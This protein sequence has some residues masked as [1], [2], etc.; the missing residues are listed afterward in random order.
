MFVGLHALFA[1]NTNTPELALTNEEGEAFMKACQNVMRHYSVHT[2]QKTIDWISLFGV[3]GG[4]YGTRVAAIIVRKR[5][6]ADPNAPRRT[7]TVTPLRTVSRE[8]SPPAS[9]GLNFGPDVF[10]D[11]EPDL[12]A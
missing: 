3:A 8:T 12:S 5:G 1:V 11:H 4:I 10:G 2:T 6:E 9:D 7:A